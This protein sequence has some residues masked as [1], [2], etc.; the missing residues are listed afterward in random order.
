[1][2]KNLLPKFIAI[3]Y[4]FSVETITYQEVCRGTLTV[5]SNLCSLGCTVIYILSPLLSILMCAP[6]KGFLARGY[7]GI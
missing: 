4:F 2:L 1:M 5:P 7:V 3:S 6:E